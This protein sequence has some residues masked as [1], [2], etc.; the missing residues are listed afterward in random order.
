MEWSSIIVLID[1]GKAFSISMKHCCWYTHCFAPW[2]VSKTSTIPLTFR[3]MYNR[4]WIITLLLW[5]MAV[6][7]S[8][9][10]AFWWNPYR[11]NKQKKC[12]AKQTPLNFEIDTSYFPPN[13]NVF[14]IKI[15]VQ[16]VALKVR[17]RSIEFSIS[18]LLCNCVTQSSFIWERHETSNLKCALYIS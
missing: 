18:S 2:K 11:L 14:L 15:Q 13:L 17:S 3:E 10:I 9:R 5:V 16:H 4:D 1:W 7:A 12:L 8:P 6:L